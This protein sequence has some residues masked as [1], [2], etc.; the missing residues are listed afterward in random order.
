MFQGINGKAQARPPQA[1]RFPC[2]SCNVGTA[3]TAG[4]I[5]GYCEI[6]RHA[7]SAVAEPPRPPNGKPSRPP[8]QDTEAQ[9]DTGTQEHILPEGCVSVSTVSSVSP[10]VSVSSVSE[11]LHA[12]FEA[13]MKKPMPPI[14]NRYYLP[15]LK[16]L[17]AL[18]AELQIAAR[19]GTFFL[20]C[21]DASDL[22]GVDFQ[23]ASRWLNKLEKDK[24]IFL[25]EQGSKP[26]DKTPIKDRKANEYR[27]LGGRD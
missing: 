8:T 12:V 7:A 6:D 13:A 23:K 21:R 11:F 18:C 17:V 15:K 2:P 27:F 19:E 24:V 16:L 1:E 5:C 9:S 14:A 22:I 4:K 10:C 3:A 20:S 25:V 26:A